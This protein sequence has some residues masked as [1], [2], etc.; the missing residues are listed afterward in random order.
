MARPRRRTGNRSFPKRSKL[1]IPFDKTIGLETANA[2][3]S[4]ANLL[5]GYF[6]QTGEEV[7]IG[8]TIGPIRGLWSLGPNV[9]TV[10]GN[11][12]I[13]AAI[14]LVP[15]GGRAV[16]PR[17]DVDIMDGMWY[18]QLNANMALSEIAA[19]T[20]S[21]QPMTVNEKFETQAKRKTS[22]NG[23]ELLLTAVSDTTIDYNVY[24]FGM[25]MITLP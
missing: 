6:S 2:A 23:Q 15:E 18:G 12:G 11:I 17:P 9:L 20:F 4:T 5:E 3:V 10:I 21:A 25:I 22:G 8:S 7:P 13:M 1:W 24:V 14:Q 19:G 16:L